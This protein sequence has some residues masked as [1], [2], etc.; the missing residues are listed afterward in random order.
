MTHSI[1]ILC[2]YC[3][4]ASDLPIPT[5]DST[6]KLHCDKCNQVT[7]ACDGSCVLNHKLLLCQVKLHP[8]NSPKL[9]QQ[10]HRL[11]S[12]YHRT[13][14]QLM[15]HIQQF[16]N[17]DPIFTVNSTTN[18][19]PSDI[20]QD[21]LSISSNDSPFPDNHDIIGNQLTMLPMCNTEHIEGQ[22]LNPVFISNNSN[23]LN[24]VNNTLQFGRQHATKLLICKAAFQKMSYTEQI[25]SIPLENIALLVTTP[26]L[27]IHQCGICAPYI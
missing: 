27:S 11:K 3:S 6:T 12:F 8:H 16:H 23:Y 19:T 21:N 17:Q 26:C 25:A 20:S 13:N 2:R 22:P 24:Y 5:N 7:Y 18:V 1:S 10:F 4:P 9:R 14:T 15:K